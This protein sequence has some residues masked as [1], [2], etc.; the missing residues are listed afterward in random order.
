MEPRGRNFQCVSLGYSG[1][2]SRPRF[3]LQRYTSVRAALGYAHAAL[4]QI[5]RR[6]T[7]RKRERER[8]RERERGRET[9]VLLIASPVTPATYTRQI[10][11][12]SRFARA[13][14]S[15]SSNKRERAV[16]RGP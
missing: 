8:E 14:V 9:T 5:L 15:P 11:Y 2:R 7:W 12:S 6:D 10:F 3:S 13:L 16:E 1:P 4:F